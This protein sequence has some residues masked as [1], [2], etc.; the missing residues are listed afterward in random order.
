MASSKIFEIFFSK[1]PHCATLSIE[2]VEERIPLELTSLAHDEACA[3]HLASAGLADVDEVQRRQ[4]QELLDQL[5][6]ANDAPLRRT[7]WAEHDIEVSSARPI[8]QKYY[9]VSKK[10]E[11]EMHR[12]VREMLEAGIIVKSASE[13]SSPVVMQRKANHTYRFCIDYR[14]LNAVTKASPYPLPHMDAILRKL[15][16]ARYISTIDLSSAY[17]QIPLRK[18]AQALTNFTAPGMGL[19]EF[20]RMPYGVVGGPATIQEL[21][22]RII[23]PEMEPHA[24]SYLED[25]IIV[26]ETFEKDLKWLSHVLQRIKDAGLTINRRKSEFCR[27][28][29]KFLGVLVNRDGFKPDPDKIAPILEYPAPK[30]LKQLKRFLGMVS[31]YCKFLPDFATIAEPLTQLTK[32]NLRI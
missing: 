16:D 7:S 30:N 11:E 29:V 17:H 8:K 3:I 9:P 13:W 1:L 27:S 15:Q 22:D 26:M 18:E 20:T 10:L 12:Q 21:S 6:P 5:L 25:I 32:H 4:L 24:F 23:G 14:K 28:E 2:G 19:F 31:W